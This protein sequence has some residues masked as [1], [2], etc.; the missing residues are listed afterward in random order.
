LGVSVNTVRT[1]VSSILTKLGLEKR[2]DV[3]MDWPGM[4]GVWG[5]KSKSFGDH[6]MQLAIYMTAIRV[7]SLETAVPFYDGLLGQTGVLVSP[8]RHYYYLGGVAFALREPYAHDLDLLPNPDWIYIATDDLEE[9]RRN[10]DAVHATVIE[11][12][13]VHPWGAR[14]FYLRDLD[15]NGLC[16]TDETTIRHYDE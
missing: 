5:M 15:G 12:V 11:D 13:Q 7:K 14:S 8:G 9:A 6:T 16:F 1:H 10:A 4:P 2:T 3:M